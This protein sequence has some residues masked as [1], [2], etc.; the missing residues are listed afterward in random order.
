MSD[1]NVPEA[2]D[3][4]VSASTRSTEAEDEQVHAGA[5]REPTPEEEAVADALPQVDD[6]VAQNYKRQAQVGAAVEGEGEIS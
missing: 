6:E 1:E 5:D 2:D 4:N 3:E